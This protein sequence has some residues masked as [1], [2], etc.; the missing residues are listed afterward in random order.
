MLSSVRPLSR[1]WRRKSTASRRAPW[2][3]LSTGIRAVDHAVE[4]ICS[5]NGQPI[6]EGASYHALRLLGPGLPAVRADPADL[7]ARLDCQI[8]ARMSMVGSE[9]R[10]RQ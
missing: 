1:R 6:A 4:D 10:V 3:F 5:V 2:L 7:E 9:T 8:A